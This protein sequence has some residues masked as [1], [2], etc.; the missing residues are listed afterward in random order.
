M[1]M[2]IRALTKP[3][4]SEYGFSHFSARSA[5]SFLSKV[6]DSLPSK[7]CVDATKGEKGRRCSRHASR[8][9]FFFS[10][11]WAS[12][13]LR[14]S[15]DRWD[16]V[17]TSV[18]RTSMMQSVPRAQ[19]PQTKM[20]PRSSVRLFWKRRLTAGLVGFP[21]LDLGSEARLVWIGKGLGS[22]VAQLISNL[23]VP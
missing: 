3:Q 16:F 8:Y 9:F 6:G 11:L 10:L 2:L 20:S 1:A 19:R 17:S 23:V 4:I 7:P 13:T 5:D 21:G 15:L 12:N 14:G 22:K 18:I